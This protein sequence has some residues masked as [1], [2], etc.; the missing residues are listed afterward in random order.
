MTCTSTLATPLL[1]P[2]SASC[3]VKAPNQK[4][5]GPLDLWPAIAAVSPSGGRDRGQFGFP[6][7]MSSTD[8]SSWILCLPKTLV[9]QHLDFSTSLTMPQDF[10]SLLV[11]VNS[12]DHLLPELSSGTLQ[13]LGHH[14]LAY[15]FPFRWTLAKS[16]W[17]TLRITSSSLALNKR[18]CHLKHHGKAAN[19]RRPATCGKTFGS[20]LSWSPRSL[21]WMM[22]CLLP[23]S[24]LRRGIPFQGQVATARSNGSLV[25]L[26][27]VSLA[28]FSMR[29]KPN[30][31][32]C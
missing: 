3:V 23:P 32:K 14:G 8:I 18:S 15:P 20:K 7:S 17:P 24:S 21:A 25:F 22:F 10:K 9:A 11:L 16:T 29:Q 5:S 28:H 4:L 2:C 27:Y 30:N 6:T 19:V 12:K 13:L 31:W 26:N 1:S